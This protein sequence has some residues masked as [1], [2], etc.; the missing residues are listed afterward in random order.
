MGRLV[1]LGALRRNPNRPASVRTVDSYRQCLTRV[2]RD[3]A[4]EGRELRDLTPETAIE[5]LQARTDFGQ[6]H[7]DMHRQAI[8]AMLAP[9]HRPT[10][11]GWPPSRRPLQP[12]A[13]EEGPRLHAHSVPAHRRGAD[14][15]ARA[16]D[17]DRARGGA[18]R[19]RAADPCPPRRAPAR[20]PARAGE[21]VRRPAGA[22]LHRRRQGRSRPPRPPSPRPRR[23]PRGAPPCRTLPRHRPR[24]PLRLAT[25]SAPAAA[26]ARASPPPPS[27][28]SGGAPGRTAAATPMPRSACGSF[29]ATC[30]GATRSRPLARNSGTFGRENR[31]VPAVTHPNCDHRQSR[32][33]LLATSRGRC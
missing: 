22:R 17:R 25:T 11:E 3:L 27:V 2:A 32:L 18:A 26:G 20:P 6:K 8:Q 14:R 30:P 16:G 7:L 10:P 13:R 9:R 31:G 19:P 12:A 24:R 21:Q 23:P 28:R 29:N 33:D 4:A 1:N 15:A 5:Y